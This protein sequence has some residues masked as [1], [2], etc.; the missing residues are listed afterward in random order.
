MAD[1]IKT[2]V[3]EELRQSQSPEGLIELGNRRHGSTWETQQI[4]WRGRTTGMDCKC[5]Y[6]LHPS[7]PQ[8]FL[9]SNQLN[10]LLSKMLPELAFVRC[11]VVD[12]HTVY[13]TWPKWKHPGGMREIEE[14]V[15]RKGAR[16]NGCIMSLIEAETPWLWRRHQLIPN[17]PFQPMLSTWYQTHCP[18]SPP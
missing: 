1:A 14:W 3:L 13:L 5:H 7:W 6:E 12:T 15:A 9:T 16:K 10:G 17:R 4:V 11:L 2:S 18:R 8:S